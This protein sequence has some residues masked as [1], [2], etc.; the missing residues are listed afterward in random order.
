MSKI[1]VRDRNKNT[2]RKPNWGYRFEI[3]KV[4]GKR[5]WASE[6]GFRTKKEAEEAGAKAFADYNGITVQNKYASISVSDFIDIWIEQYCTPNFKYNSQKAYIQVINQ[7]IKPALGKY[8][9]T[10]I[11]SIIVNEFISEVVKGNKSPRLYYRILGVLRSVFTY[12]IH[13]LRIINNNPTDY[14]K[15]PKSA[16]KKKP[17]EREV[18][19]PEEFGTIMELYPFGNKFHIPLLLGWYNGMR[20]GEVFGLVWEDIDFKNKVINVERQDEVSRLKGDI[21]EIQCSPPKYDSVRKISIGDNLL[22]EL[23]REKQRQ[24]KAEALAGDEGY[25]SYI[26]DD[27]TIIQVKKKLR[28]D[29]TGKKIVHPIIIADNGRII[30]R[31]YIEQVCRKISK[32]LGKNITFHCLRHSNTTT[33]YE[34]GVPVK[35]IQQ[36]LGHKSPETT[37]K[38]YAHNTQKMTDIAVSTIDDCLI[39]S[40][41]RKRKNV[42]TLLN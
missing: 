19:T 30:C 13:P 32:Q 18:V 39:H 7:Y 23:L 2:G 34:N 15:I 16:Q 8:Y 38:T 22:Q 5:Q 6:S 28:P 31:A 24:E 11:T 3:A 26:K 36:R 33:L 10:K 40:L 9:L 1:S 42:D 41:N 12:A 25:I 29:L 4:N 17:K 14:I 21:V 20:H 27:A 35:A 37:M